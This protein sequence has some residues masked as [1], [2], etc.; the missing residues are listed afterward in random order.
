MKK[1]EQPR[2]VIDIEDLREI[3]PQKNA[4]TADQELAKVAGGAKKPCPKTSMMC[5][6]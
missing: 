6:L 2:V 5:P 4:E 3:A 1:N